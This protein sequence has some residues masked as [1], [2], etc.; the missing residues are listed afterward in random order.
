[1]IL[2][3]GPFLI[4]IGIVI[5]ILLTRLADSLAQYFDQ[6]SEWVILLAA[7]AFGGLGSEGIEVPLNYDMIVVGF[8]MMLTLGV[9][10]WLVSRRTA[11]RN[12]KKEEDKPSP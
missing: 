1:M 3:V 5:T 9:L 7:A 2:Y 8:G 4:A 6:E 10:A 12:N 11:A